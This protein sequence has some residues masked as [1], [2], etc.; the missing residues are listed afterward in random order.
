MHHHSQADTQREGNAKSN[1]AISENSYYLGIDCG[2]FDA[3]YCLLTAGHQKS[4]HVVSLNRSMDEIASS[5]A[6][7]VARIVPKD[8][9]R[10]TIST[11][12]GGANPDSLITCLT[13]RFPA[14]EIK[15]V[16][17]HDPRVAPW[18]ALSHTF[19]G[20]LFVLDIGWEATRLQ[21]LVDDNGPHVLGS[22]LVTSYHG[23]QIDKG[24]LATLYEFDLI[25]DIE[26]AFADIN[27]QAYQLVLATKLKLAN[28]E[29]VSVGDE[30]LRIRARIFEKDLFSKTAWGNFPAGLVD[31]DLLRIIEEEETGLVL[32][33]S[34]FRLPWLAGT[35]KKRLPPRLQ[36]L[37]VLG[38][39]GYVRAFGLATQAQAVA[40][41]GSAAR[42]QDDRFEIGLSEETDG[43]QTE[44]PTAD[45]LDAW[46]SEL[47]ADPRHAARLALRFAD[48]L[49]SIFDVTGDR[50]TPRRIDCAP[51]VTDLWEDGVARV[52]LQCFL[53]AADANPGFPRYLGG[54]SLTVPADDRGYSLSFRLVQQ[55]PLRLRTRVLTA[56]GRLFGQETD[57]NVEETAGRD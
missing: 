29:M 20:H 48:Q 12:L 41:A 38:D 36:R 24:I 1:Q 55:H 14:T 43:G 46:Q 17:L 2:C 57:W 11:D 32:A 39:P 34:S 33:G 49:E 40:T 27:S 45:E 5:L 26:T 35:L 23:R 21:F 6:E 56:D 19:D 28:L 4:G 53:T 50:A 52:E 30:D 18:H 15:S 7:E 42:Q 13:N 16:D 54:C 22:K 8:A 51:L 44:P 37:D 9:H 3:K 10:L 31:D 25:D 47:T